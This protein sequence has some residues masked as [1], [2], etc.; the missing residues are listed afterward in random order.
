M[1]PNS[2]KADDDDDNP[3]T[4]E[5]NDDD[6]E[7][8]KGTDNDNNTVEENTNEDKMMVPLNIRL[9]ASRTENFVLAASYTHRIEKAKSTTSN[10]SGKNNSIALESHLYKSKPFVLANIP[11]LTTPL[12]PLQE[13]SD[14][15]NA[16]A[17]P[18]VSP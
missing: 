7:K 2:K 6:E 17:S 4:I 15:T 14:S 8:K 3:K 13:S 1:G 11:K 16:G 9:V 18:Q 5:S 10:E 12:A